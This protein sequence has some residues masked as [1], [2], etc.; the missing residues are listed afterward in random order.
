MIRQFLSRL[1][2]AAALAAVLA[3]LGACSNGNNNN[4]QTTAVGIGVGA[5]LDFVIG[6]IPRAPRW[7]SNA[8]L[9]WA[10][11]LAREP[12]RLA[13]RYLVKDP[14]FL[15]VVARTLRMPRVERVRP[16]A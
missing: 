1:V 12:R 8:G 4:T 9:E 2:L 5:S 11:R 14:R 13:H 7:V 16:G 10:Y 15:A 6:R 3:G